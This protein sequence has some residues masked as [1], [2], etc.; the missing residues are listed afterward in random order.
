MRFVLTSDGFSTPEIVGRC[1]ELVGQPAE[2]IKVAAV[3]EAHVDI[4]GSH[5][6]LLDDLGRAKNNFGY[7]ELV[8]LQALAI[9]QVVDRLGP[10]DIIFVTGGDPDYLMSVFNKTGFGRRLPKLLQNKVYVGSSAGSMV[11]GQRVGAT[12][13]LQ[14]YGESTDDR[15]GV[16]DWLELVE[17]AVHPHFGDEGL[18]NDRPEVLLESLRG[19]RGVVYAIGDGAAIVSDGGQ[20]T[21]IGPEPLV[22][23]D[24]RPANP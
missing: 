4:H 12:A 14:I 20:L 10:A 23:K 18:P 8:N 21:V 3:S 1:V 7:I 15:Y 17:L 6:W 24:G 9:G 5:G 13:Y 19:Y 11:V 22:V 2:A 16:S